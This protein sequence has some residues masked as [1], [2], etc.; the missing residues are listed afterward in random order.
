MT[1]KDR[2]IFEAAFF[3]D[4]QAIDIAV[5]NG[6]SP[7]APH[8]KA[9][10]TPLQVACEAD[11]VE[12][13]RKLLELGADPNKRFTKISMV[14]GHVISKDSVPL[15]HVK[16]TAAAEM[17]IRFGARLDIKDGKGYRPLDW[18]RSDGNAPLVEFLS[19]MDSQ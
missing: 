5:R 19:K 2:S 1:N 12:A 18:A 3:G 8:P 13:I 17:L 9:G 4:S 16:S 6:V 15:M 7:D 14:D 10:H 11:A